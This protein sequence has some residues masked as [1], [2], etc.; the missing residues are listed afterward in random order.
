M[1]YS[2][3]TSHDLNDIINNITLEPIEVSDE[4]KLV[5]VDT[6]F[7]I[8]DSM[9]IVT[10]ADE[11]TIA[12]Y[13]AQPNGLQSVVDAI[14]AQAMVVV[15]IETDEG[16]KQLDFMAKRIKKA[17][18]VLDDMGKAQCDIYKAFPAKID[19]T[20]RSMRKQLEFLAEK[21]RKPLTELESKVSLLS[22]LKY[23]SASVLECKTFVELNE[24]VGLVKATSKEK[25]Y[26][27]KMYND[28]VAVSEVLWQSIETTEARLTQE[29]KDREDL[30]RLRAKEAQ[31]LAKSYQAQWKEDKPSASA[32]KLTRIRVMLEDATKYASRQDVIACVVDLIA[33]GKI[34]GVKIV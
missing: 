7:S 17:C 19:D 13:L 31:E 12:Q 25:E 29:Q 26:W 9:G 28:F 3:L 32:I 30:E 21:V 2:K 8:D 18:K 34:E 6:V 20:R 27:G 14:K 16:L 22:E 11:A 1:N 10:T 23:K 33:Q 24:V 15:D 4:I 5:V